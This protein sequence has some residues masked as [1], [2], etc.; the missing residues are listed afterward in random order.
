MRNLNRQNHKLEP[1]TFFLDY[2][3]QLYLHMQGHSPT[4]RNG[5]RAPPSSSCSTLP[6]ELGPHRRLAGG[7]QRRCRTIDP[8]H[9]C[10]PT[11]FRLPVFPL[12]PRPHPSPPP[13]PQAPQAPKLQIRPPVPRFG[14]LR[15]GSGWPR[16][17]VFV[18]GVW[19]RALAGGAVVPAAVRFTGLW[20]ALPTLFSLSCLLCGARSG[21]GRPPV[22]TCFPMRSPSRWALLWGFVVWSRA[23]PG[24]IRRIKKLRG[25]RN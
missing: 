18:R 6:T 8:S 20:V 25:W 1:H 15:D 12:L 2:I 9:A 7:G 22:L 19:A 21:W 5:L 10:F 14:P 23:R 17:C 13:R 4:K 3:L 11:F 16:V 24:R